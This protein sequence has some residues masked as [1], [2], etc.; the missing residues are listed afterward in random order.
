MSDPIDR[1]PRIQPELPVHQFEIPA[2]PE[3]PENTAWA[4]L[5]AALP[6]FTVAG[7]LCLIFSRSGV[8]PLFYLPMA[9]GMSLS[10]GLA[11]LNNRQNKKLRA[12]R[13]AAYAERLLELRQDMDRYHEAQR[14][15]YH[16][17]YP[18]HE[19]ALQI[20]ADLYMGESERQTHIR[21]GSRLWER[22]I[23]DNDF[24]VIRLGVGTVPSTVIYQFNQPESLDDPQVRDALRLDEDSR[25]LR[26]APVVL[27]LRQRPVASVSPSTHGGDGEE[28]PEPVVSQPLPH[29]PSVHALG[30]TGTEDGIYE[31]VN[32]WLV[33]YTT[34]HA[35]AETRLFV[36]GNRQA[37]WMWLKK[38]PE[39]EDEGYCLPHCQGDGQN[40]FLYFADSQ[41]QPTAE[42][43]EEEKA[44]RDESRFLEK[45]RKILVQRQLRLQDTEGGQG[46]DP[47]IPFLLVVVDFLH[48]TEGAGRTSPTL[49]SLEEDATISMLLQQGN[50]L[51]AAVIFLVPEPS[52]VPA[53]CLAVV[54]VRPDTRPSAAGFVF[55]YAEVGLNRQQYVGQADFIREKKYLL[56]SQQAIN[57]SSKEQ[58][59]QF[60]RDLTGLDVRKQYGATLVDRLPF[61]E[62]MG[63][64]TV[65][66]LKER[67][68]KDW[69]KSRTPKA[70]DWLRV[71]LGFM[72]GNKPRQL[73]FSAKEDGVHGMIAGSTGSGKSEILISLIVGL[74]VKYDPTILNFVLVDFKGG[75]AFQ[76]F[77]NKNLPHCVDVITNLEGSGG[78]GRMFTAIRAEL[79]ERQKRLK[80]AKRQDIIEYH[81]NPPADGRPMPFLFIIIDEFAEMLTGHSEFRSQLESI[82]RIG[83]SLGVSLILA[84][85]RPSGVTDQMRSN[86]KLRLCLRV[87]N[88][89]ESREILRR[90]DAHY[91]PSGIPGRGYL[92]VGNE[93]LDIIQVAYAGD[94][95]ATEP[96]R[97][98]R[99]PTR[100]AD[101][102]RDQEPLKLYQA[103]ITT[104]AEL[105]QAEGRPAQSAPWPKFLPADLSL[106][107]PPQ[108]EKADDE[109]RTVTA[110]Y[111]YTTYLKNKE[112]EKIITLGTEP[113]SKKKLV[114]NP[115]VNRWLNKENV[116]ESLPL[117]WEHYAMKPV[118]GL[119]DDPVAAEVLP[120]I[121][122]L[123]K[124]HVAVFGESKA[125]KTG[126]VRT[127]ILSLAATH[128]PDQFQAYLLD[129][130]GRNLESLI[131]FPHIG[132]VILPDE[133][134]YEDRVQFL[135]RE[136]D[137]QVE[138]RKA[139]FSSASQNDLYSY[140]A[141]S[142]PTSRFPAVLLV[143]DNFVEFKETFVTKSEDHAGLLET[144]ITLARQGNKYG[145]HIL[146][147]VHHLNVLS[148]ALYSLFPERM[149][150][151]LSEPGDYREIVGSVSQLR[152]KPGRGYT[153]P[154]RQPLEF[155]VARPV[156]IAAKI[157]EAG[158]GNEEK[159]LRDIAKRMS[160]FWG[161]APTPSA[162][163]PLPT[164]L[165]LKELIAEPWGIPKDETFI[166]A[167]Y[168]KARE[169]W[170][171]STGAGTKADW[172]QVPLGRKTGNELFRLRF[173][174]EHD[175]VHGMVA[176]GTGSGKSELLT[177]L[178]ASLALHY[179]PSILN[180][181]LVD[182][183]GGGAFK[184]F[185]KLPHC[186]D[187]ITNLQTGGAQRMFTAIDAELKRRQK[188]NADTNTKDIVEYRQQGLHSNGGLPYPHL[189][190]I[191]DE[192][193]EMIRDNEEFRNKLDQITR[194]GRASGVS[195]ILASQKPTGVTDQMRANIR[196][197]ICLR[198][199]NPDDSR[200]VIRRPD[201]ADLPA[202]RPGRG[203]LQV[204]SDNLKLIQV[205]YSAGEEKMGKSP[206]T[207]WPGRAKA[208]NSST[209]QGKYPRLYEVMIRLAQ[210]LAAENEP[211][212][213]PRR[214][215]PAFLP[216]QLDLETPLPRP[217]G[218]EQE[219]QNCGLTLQG[220]SY[221]LN[222]AIT[223]WLNGE[224]C[225]PGVCWKEGK[226]GLTRAMRPVLGLED[227]PS[228][229]KQ[230]PLQLRLDKSHLIVFGDSGWG[231]T[232]LLRT[233][234]TS[235]A[236]THS[237]Q[238]LHAYVLD[239]GGRHFDALATLP[240]L[241]A[242]ISPAEEAYQ[243]RVQ[244][245]FNRLDVEVERRQELFNNAGKVN[246][247][248]DYNHWITTL[249][250]PS[251][252]G[253][254]APP[255]EP[256]ILV[257]IDNFA[258]LNESFPS[259]VETTLVPLLRNCQAYG[260][261]FA[262]SA[263][264]P[265]VLPTRLYNLFAERLTFKLTDED[266]YSD[267]VGRGPGGLGPIRGR[268]YIRRDR[269]RLECQIAEPVASTRG[270]VSAARKTT[271]LERLAAHMSIA[272]E[273]QGPEKIEI[274]PK[275][276]SLLEVLI[277]A[278]GLSAA[279]PAELL[280][281]FK[282][283]T[284]VGG[285]IQAV[286]GRNASLK[287]AVFELQTEGYHFAITG[288]PLSG[289][290]TALYNL[291]LS[292]AA[293]YPPEQ[294][295]LVLV[296][297][298]HRFIAYGTGEEESLSRLPHVVATV[299]EMSELDAVTAR[300]EKEG[301]E[302]TF[303]DQQIFVVIDD[304]D[305]LELDK[306]AHAKIADRL[307]T[308]ARRYG[309]HI[310]F[311]VAGTTLG[312]ATTFRRTILLARYGLGLRID[313]SLDNLGV[314]KM[315][316]GLRDGELAVG[317][318]YRV[319]AGQTQMVQLALPH[320]LPKTQDGLV[321]L[322][323]NQPII[324]ALSD[325]IQ[326]IL[327]TFEPA[328]E[329]WPLPKLSETSSSS[330]IHMIKIV[331]MIRQKLAEKKIDVPSSTEAAVLVEWFWQVI[332]KDP[333][334]STFIKETAVR[335]L[336][337]DSD[338][339]SRIEF[340]NGYLNLK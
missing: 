173:S 259:L 318:G 113:E 337:P 143:I 194:V 45:L 69:Q 330:D 145:I 77:E 180:F 5:Q 155:Q 8:N 316:A 292:L 283:Q 297:P 56:P 10:I 333:N 52:K 7:S 163:P 202:G 290:T 249:H 172:L 16:Y 233:L 234:L 276:V 192:Y 161:D 84:A 253:T 86:I 147:T 58:L 91:L 94:I 252:D 95:Y 331:E 130:G 246:N 123:R 295:V 34:F 245:M 335:T 216:P 51:G 336:G 98:V 248:Y 40:Q 232:T 254:S 222:A 282:Q 324:S 46:S 200:E 170:N 262:V 326:A 181:V 203:Y 294:V 322:A 33:H 166:D 87:E 307:N 289:K 212:R 31:I 258:E 179:D 169:Q 325:W 24:G 213:Q 6:L 256:A 32:A 176:G 47:T 201:A 100:R 76:E 299:S 11:F 65:E 81:R 208:A 265:N 85:Q 117:D 193:A 109:K 183:K 186:V 118:I 41:P 207:I 157:E 43:R 227:N 317:R 63:L 36:I 82:T 320:I 219:I 70:A 93:N 323:S 284:L 20:A 268:A 237:P 229:A 13:E 171:H 242:I 127:L 88:P 49:S 115:F 9:V 313:K 55:R 30:V 159:A 158:V 339:A 15:F 291:V 226:V 300:L 303:P 141:A 271:P 184:P 296:D 247:L 220:D 160:D 153:R 106:T 334:I 111:S 67:A 217:K 150:L 73:I 151:R 241:G 131:Q 302:P 38:E 309:K 224:G 64:S 132:D 236:A 243:E 175:G 89:E 267:I 306:T 190:I 62:L 255:I 17:N 68:K 301:K 287:P 311:I 177:T 92:Q 304:F 205:A 223:N 90:S 210:E 329:V 257:I 308:V 3:K 96:V 116:W 39:R 315:P 293:R 198:V 120:L 189:F 107:D 332:M 286:L 164:T 312:G 125:G 218:A 12:E 230:P 328:Q 22:R 119:V 101:Q 53:A 260:I 122:H 228:E 162:I 156:G 168:V 140:N 264:A 278:T 321:T 23:D 225:W 305:D 42:T 35:P 80:Q 274:L 74:A 19:T 99:W 314:Y 102:A 134:G 26:D 104:L 103:I 27:S 231:K 244:R 136:L 135:L 137:R 72:S 57:V 139:A 340:I 250:T 79:E 285:K 185:E 25:Y 214:P 279:T 144:F 152:D 124:G 97:P 251:V 121:V 240:H 277:E 108:P 71:K 310:H 221:F 270:W 215:W 4:S 44:E 191:I 187:S 59:N 105:A 195:L 54:D 261:H 146:I 206:A 129:L 148:G 28:Q 2:P 83:R 18:D 272:G 133:E 288:P 263:N 78:V 21:S 126:L 50:V 128:A 14:R 275:V 239:L 281:Q 235:L 154:D 37:P 319:R 178:I 182:Y 142:S 209:S 75:G 61:L 338:I 298:L 269:Q 204:G 167:L 165:S 114:L 112:L 280:A 110:D 60:A 196:F 66:Q 199:E 149:A 211:D 138:I 197:R 327:G 188:L 238:E 266:L 273:K 1:P 174:A 48:P 29:I